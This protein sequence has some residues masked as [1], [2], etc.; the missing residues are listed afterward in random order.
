MADVDHINWFKD[1]WEFVNGAFGRPNL[2]TF[3]NNPGRYYVDGAESLWLPD[4]VEGQDFIIT[5]DHNR[6]PS[7][8]QTTRIGSNKR[9]INGRMR[10]YHIADKLAVDVSWDDLPSRAYS[11]LGGYEAW[12]ADPENIT[13][14]T[15]DG[16][17]GGVELL[18]WWQEHYGSFWV[19]FSF[20]GVPVE[21]PSNIVFNGYS[22]V[23]EMTIIDFDY[24]ISKRSQGVPASSGG[25]YHLDF[26][27]V[28]LR[29]EES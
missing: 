8:F 19:F 24:E 12:K 2:I 9:M 10:S 11:E 4:G 1:R 26:W 21:I 20:D 29:L 13:K 14:F 17:A 16:G 7:P 22:R 5:S 18:K 23:Y 15:V 6:S 25:F 28:S 27:N 3:S